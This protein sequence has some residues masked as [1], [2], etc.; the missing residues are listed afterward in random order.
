M[1]G[2]QHI[3]CYT[4]LWLMKY[5]TTKQLGLLGQS[6][7]LFVSEAKPPSS[8]LLLEQSLLFD[9]IV[10]HSLLQVIKPTCYSDNQ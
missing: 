5:P 3:G 9:E 4:C 6:N 2:K 10:D 8:K 7:A 1:P